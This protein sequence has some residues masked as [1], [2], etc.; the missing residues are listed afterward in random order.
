[1]GELVAYQWA[2]V[3][4]MLYFGIYFVIGTAIKNNSIVD[5]GWGLGFVITHWILAVQFDRW[6]FGNLIVG[7]LVSIWGIRLSIHLFRRNF[8]KPEDFR[9]ANWRQ[10]WGKWVAVRAFFKVYLLQGVMMWLI[11]MPVFMLSALD[12]SSF[13]MRFGMVGVGLGICIWLIGFYFEVVGDWQL[14]AF[15]KG[16]GNKGKI[17]KTGLWR[18]TRHP[19]YF[20]EAMIWWGI[21]LVSVSS[22]APIYTIVSPILI[23]Y[24]LRFVSGVPL[25][26]KN[27]EG[28]E[29]F[30]EYKEKTPIFIPWW[31]K[32]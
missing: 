4:I 22:G 6:H 25:L 32:A 23:N 24:L 14:E 16:V 30:S 18:Y 28:R 1:M 11:G 9:Y 10:Q 29:G 31:P 12:K 13:Q 7:A 19:N 17:L 21:W 20:G 26:E 8:A 2:F 27:F 3:W 15:K 5:I